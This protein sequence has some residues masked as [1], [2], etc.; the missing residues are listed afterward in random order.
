MFDTAKVLAQFGFRSPQ[1]GACFGNGE[2]A[3]G[4]LA[5]DAVNPADETVTAKI[6][7]ASAQDYEGIV[8]GAQQAHRA[9][10]MVPPPRRGE[11][12]SR[13]GDLI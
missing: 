4:G 6:A 7:G 1:P 13:I 10:R 3:N 2:W 11:L 12:V 9:W 8:S 5:F